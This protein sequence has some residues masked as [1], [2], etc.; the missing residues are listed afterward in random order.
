MI[1]QG[2]TRI[3]ASVMAVILLAACEAKDQAKPGSAI[4]LTFTGQSLSEYFFILENPTSETIYFRGTRRLWSTTI[5]VDI[6]F[7]C[8]NNK[9]GEGTVGGFPLFDGGKD[10]PAIVVMPGKAMEIKVTTF[11]SGFKLDEH[12][13]E[14]CHMHLGLWEPN[15]SRPSS[16]NVDSD[17]FQA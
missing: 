1:P 13:G 8:Q 17:G 16:K 10:P 6:A 4:S 14:P 12:K 3:L 15:T 7:D 5:P 11:A 9:T 2:T